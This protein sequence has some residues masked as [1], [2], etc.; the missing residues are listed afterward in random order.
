M[1][2]S[3]TESEMTKILTE[4]QL[5]EVAKKNYIHPKMDCRFRFW[6]GEIRHI[7]T[8]LAWRGENGEKLWELAKA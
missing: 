5:L 6:I 2:V 1:Q 8:P 7:A 4:A 3:E